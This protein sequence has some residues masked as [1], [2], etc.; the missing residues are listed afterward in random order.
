MSKTIWDQLALVIMSGMREEEYLH[1]CTVARIR[2]F[3]SVCQELRT[4][5]NCN[6]YYC[7]NRFISYDLKPFYL[8]GENI[9]R[10]INRPKLITSRWHNKRVKLGLLSYN[11]LLIL[12]TLC[13]LFALSSKLLYKAT[14]WHWLLWE[15]VRNKDISITESHLS[16]LYALVHAMS[17]MAFSV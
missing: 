4:C 15:T 13:H 2:L 9:L 16:W 1:D 5:F 14:H 6:P 3:K 8:S 10:G 7:Y 12:I 17:G 11:P